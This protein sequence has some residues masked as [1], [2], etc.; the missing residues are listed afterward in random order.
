MDDRQ[1]FVDW[2]V[3]NRGEDPAFLGEIIDDGLD[4]ESLKPFIDGF[5]R[6]FGIDPAQ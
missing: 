1:A 2:M 4:K 3:K 5:W 6:V